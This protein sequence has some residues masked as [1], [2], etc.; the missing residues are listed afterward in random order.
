M[1]YIDG[2][3]EYEAG[4]TFRTL[5]MWGDESKEFFDKYSQ[6]HEHLYVGYIPISEFSFDR[7]VIPVTLSNY[8][9]NKG[10]LKTLAHDQIECGANRELEDF[11]KLCW[12]TDEFLNEGQL[13]NPIG[14][15]YNPR[16]RQ[17]IIHPGG[18]RQI[19]L[20]LFC[21]ESDRVECFY[22]NTDGVQFDFMKDL[23]RIKA[24]D[25]P[26]HAHISLVADHGSLI[27][28]IH[29][30]HIELDGKHENIIV[31]GVSRYLEILKNNFKS[32]SFSSNLDIDYLSQWQTQSD[33][34]WDVVF[35]ADHT[36][37]DMVKAV[38]LL[39]LQREYESEFLSC[40]R[41]N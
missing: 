34:D 40:K 33:P 23:T 6:S 35:K 24:S 5:Q 4:Y 14:S 29:D 1:Q 22:F 9:N 13:K 39:S 18:S 17:N 20:Q 11:A 10:F 28:H 26:K 16:L 19:V 32:L 7:E 27:P 8:F 2:K 37:R 15:H 25:L 36:D 38:I 21:D 30:T 3:V 31:L 12:L 41:L